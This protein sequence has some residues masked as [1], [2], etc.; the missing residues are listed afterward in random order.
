M[1]ACCFF[2]NK[3]PTFT[4]DLISLYQHHF[5]NNDTAVF[6][7]L[8]TYRNHLSTLNTNHHSIRLST[9]RLNTMNDAEFNLFCIDKFDQKLIQMQVISV[10]LYETL[11]RELVQLIPI[12]IQSLIGVGYYHIKSFNVLDYNLCSNIINTNTGTIALNARQMNQ[13]A[14]W[15]ITLLEDGPLSQYLRS[16]IKI[17][18]GN[19]KYPYAEGYCVYRY[20]I[21][22]LNMSYIGETGNLTE[23][24]KHHENPN[25]WNSKTEANKH[26]YLAFKILGREKFQFEILH[27]NLST[28]EEA[29]RLEAAEILNY[30]A[31][32]PNGFN[33]RNENHNL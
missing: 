15:N 31:Y 23:R 1:D 18:D 2:E 13:S 27:S 22:E 10:Y 17:N 33:I 25:S 20:W 21:P 6:V 28:E 4:D 16:H 5:L 12:E 26:L 32:Y 19:S 7:S 8:P 9:A 14:P 30:N 24:I 29:L 11:P 3:I